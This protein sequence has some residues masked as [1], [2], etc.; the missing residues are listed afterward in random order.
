MLPRLHLQREMP[1]IPDH[2]LLGT[3]RTYQEALDQLR[4]AEPAA[5]RQGGRRI[6]ELE[7]ALRYIDEELQRRGIGAAPWWAS[8]ETPGEERREEHAALE[9]QL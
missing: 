4:A 2:V 7:G 6:A 8:A 9:P 1:L 3:R 5:R